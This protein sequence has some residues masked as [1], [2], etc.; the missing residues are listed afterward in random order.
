MTRTAEQV[1]EEF[2]R[3]GIS[4]ASWA[5]ANGFSYNMVL[6]VM[7]GRKKGL[8]GQSHKIAVK[9]GMKEGELV[10]DSQIANS[11]LRTA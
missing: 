7:A 5:A 6:E 4:I 9:L 8:R 2:Q 11:M 3:K 10:A 1:R